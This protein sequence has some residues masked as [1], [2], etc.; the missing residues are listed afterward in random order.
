MSASEQSRLHLAEVALVDNQWVTSGM[1][2]YVGVANGTGPTVEAAC[3]QAYALAQ[4]VVVPNIR[5]RD[6]IGERVMTN[7]YAALQRLGYIAEG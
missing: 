2:G 4:K 1:L 5:Y 3:D 7:D 6:D